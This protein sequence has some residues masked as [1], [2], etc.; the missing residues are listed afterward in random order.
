[1]LDKLY[2]ME[3]DARAREFEDVPR[4]ERM[5]PTWR[6]VW[7]AIQE[8]A[9]YERMVADTQAAVAAHEAW[10]SA[11]H[12]LPESTQ[13]CAPLDYCMCKCCEADGWHPVGQPIVLG[14]IHDS[15]TYAFWSQSRA[16]ASWLA[17]ID[18]R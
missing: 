1:M 18:A 17:Y 16:I 6:E 2:V 5:P 13:W 11:K 10:M 15:T 14:N 12:G 3:Q 4:E 8:R 7:C 9:R